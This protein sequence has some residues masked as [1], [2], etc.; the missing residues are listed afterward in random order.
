MKLTAIVSSLVVFACI[1]G[2]SGT[3]P[4]LELAGA[5][6]KEP[7]ETVEDFYPIKGTA[8]DEDAGIAEWKVFVNGKEMGR[9]RNLV[10]R[11]K[12][13][14]EKTVALQEGD[15]EIT[16]IAIDKD[17]NEVRK[18]VHVYRK[19]VKRSIYAAV[20]GISDYKNVAKLKY[21]AA[22][23]KE[24][25]KF[26]TE[27]LG[28]PEENIT[29]LLNDDA[30]RP[31]I[32]KALR[33]TLKKKAGKPDTVFIYYA[34]HG[35]VD[36][37]SDDPDGDG[38]EKYILPVDAEREDLYAT[39]IQV[40]TLGEYFR[41]IKA[42]RIVMYMDACYAG[43]SKPNQKVRT[44]TSE[45][46]ATLSDRFLRKLSQGKGRIVMCAAG[47]S[48]VA[49][50]R[51]DLGHGVFTHYLLE[52]LRGKAD[53]DKDGF[54]TLNEGYTYILNGVTAATQRNQTPVKLGDFEGTIYL[55]GGKK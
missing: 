7:I 39:A 14:Y 28:V 27:D 48:E 49:E 22:D 1:V 47:A 34:G 15:N 51:D 23:A 5:D 17:G 44:L 6:S 31:A 55:S 13:T 54:V 8:S 9:E 21:A 3:A 29:L 11:K 26:L 45:T 43:A 42:D 50:E 2:C 38:L 12:A 4:V 52:G 40:R 25:N 20:I 30:T 53:V 35:A 37:S 19:P 16:L 32:E 24:F 41:H 33:I 10:V 18:T 46:R 36:P